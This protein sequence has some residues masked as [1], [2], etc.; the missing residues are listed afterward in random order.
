MAVFPQGE[1]ATAVI[2]S[3]SWFQKATVLSGILHSLSTESNDPAKKNR[4]S[5]GW[6]AIEVTKSLCLN[7]HRHSCLLTCHSRTVLSIEEDNK[8]LF[9]LQLKSKTSPV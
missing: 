4:S 1:N 9:L 3:G 5:V 6:K 2:R 7:V 8:K